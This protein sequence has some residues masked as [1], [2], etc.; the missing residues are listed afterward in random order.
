MIRLETLLA[1]LEQVCLESF[2]ELLVKS[3]DPLN[4]IYSI[5]VHSHPWPYSGA[6]TSI[7]DGSGGI[8]AIFHLVKE[9]KEGRLTRCTMGKT[10][11]ARSGQ[12]G[13]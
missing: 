8:R 2:L 10:A 3:K 12:R 6:V 7:K 5:Y 4:R 9:K 11:F 1:L 13:C